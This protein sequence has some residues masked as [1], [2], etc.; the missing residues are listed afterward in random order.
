MKNLKNIIKEVI[1]SKTCHCGCGGSCKVSI[2]EEKSSTSKSASKKESQ[3]KTRT[4]PLNEGLGDEFD[5]DVIERAKV[6]D[7]DISMVKKLFNGDPVKL[8]YEWT[9]TG[10]IDFKTF[11]K[12]L[13]YISQS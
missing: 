11:K 6:F 5:S 8:T 4:R 13:N 1:H 10:N 3:T 2:K 9:K 7:L 12:L